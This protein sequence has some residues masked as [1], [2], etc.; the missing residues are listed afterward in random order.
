[1][2]LAN[3]ITSIFKCKVKCAFTNIELISY[4]TLKYRGFYKE[5]EIVYPKEVSKLSSFKFL[6]YF[7]CFLHSV[8]IESGKSTIPLSIHRVSRILVFVMTLSGAP[9][10]NKW[11][12][13]M[14]SLLPQFGPLWFFGGV[15]RNPAFISLVYVH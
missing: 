7:K 8:T 12:F 15:F 14:A 1:M 4:F 11:W 10:L 9:H 3:V 13:G 6:F 2:S 5:I